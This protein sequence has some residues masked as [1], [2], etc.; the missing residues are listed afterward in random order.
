MTVML[1]MTGATKPSHRQWLR[2]IVVM[3]LSWQCAAFFAGLSLKASFL[4]R[5]P[6]KITRPHSLRESL[7]LSFLVAVVAFTDTT[8]PGRVS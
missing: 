6:H 7:L 2:V 5:Q 3:S 4:N 8:L 1:S